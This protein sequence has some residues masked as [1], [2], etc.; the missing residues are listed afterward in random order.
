MIKHSHIN[1]YM[2][3]AFQH[4]RGAVRLVSGVAQHLCSV[5]GICHDA[6]GSNN[7]LQLYMRL[8]Y[9]AALD[10][11]IKQGNLHNCLCDADSW[12]FAPVYCCVQTPKPSRIPAHGL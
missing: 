12:G 6:F 9:F 10:V 8:K 11:S 4:H 5:L 7:S 1:P 3:R 2:L